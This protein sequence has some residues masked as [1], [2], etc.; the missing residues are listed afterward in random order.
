MYVEIDRV[1]NNSAIFSN[2]QLSS[3]T[4]TWVKVRT[5]VKHV[6]GLRQLSAVEMTG[7]TKALA[8]IKK[9][10]VNGYCLKYGASEKIFSIRSSARSDV[11]RTSYCGSSALEYSIQTDEIY[12]LLV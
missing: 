9:A 10:I 5:Y 6:D 8:C 3:I 12:Q 4:A 11:L 1:Y 2:G 7:V